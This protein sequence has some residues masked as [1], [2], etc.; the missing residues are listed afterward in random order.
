[1]VV[2]HQDAGCRKSEHL[3]VFKGERSSAKK[4]DAGH[5]GRRR[6]AKAV[7]VQISQDHL[8]VGAGC[9]DCDA[10]RPSSQDRRKIAPAIDGNRLRDRNGPVGP[11]IDDIDLTT[12]GSF[13]ERARKCGAGSEAIAGIV[14]IAGACNPGARGLGRSHAVKGHQ[15]Q[16]EKREKQTWSDFE[17]YVQVSPQALVDSR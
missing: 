2:V 13:P 11:R 10:N 9:V 8:V 1:M 6:L 4:A 14:V 5:A 7:D 15:R 12:N 16:A 17:S 3:D